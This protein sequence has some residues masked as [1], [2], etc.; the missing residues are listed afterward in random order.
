MTIASLLLGT[1][2]SQIL[3]IATKVIFIHYLNLD[4]WLV[5]IA[6]YVA[7]AI[8]TI[9]VSRR[10][11]TLNYIESFFLAFVWLFTLLI[12]DFIVTATLI[13]RDMYTTTAYWLSYAVI[14]GA[15]LV[16]HKKMHIEVRKENASK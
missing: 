6:F 3:F 16:F 14:I 8:E 7:L 10:M 1:L 15:L 4:N 2:V 11:G 5:Y 13:G 9:A 12:A